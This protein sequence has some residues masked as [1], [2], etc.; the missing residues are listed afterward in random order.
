MEKLIKTAEDRI[1]NYQA[2]NGF[3][4]IFDQLNEDLEAIRQEYRKSIK[5]PIETPDND[6]ELFLKNHR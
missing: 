5:P 6:M 2:E 4:T 1:M 3:S